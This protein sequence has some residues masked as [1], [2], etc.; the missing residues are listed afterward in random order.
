VPTRGC[1]DI[2]ASAMRAAA[3]MLPDTAADA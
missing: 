1:N 2:T 3:L